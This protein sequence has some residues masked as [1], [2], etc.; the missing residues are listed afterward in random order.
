MGFGCICT[1]ISFFFLLTPRGIYALNS[2]F[3]KLAS[4]KHGLQRGDSHPALRLDANNFGITCVMNLKEGGVCNP[5]RLLY[6]PHQRPHPHGSRY[7]N[8][9]CPDLRASNPASCTYVSLFFL[10]H[11]SPLHDIKLS[12]VENEVGSRVVCPPR[13]D[14]DATAMRP[15]SAKSNEELTNRVSFVAPQT[16]QEQHT[17]VA[18]TGLLLMYTWNSKS[19]NPTPAVPP[20]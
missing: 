10:S 5:R 20:L 2:Q 14:R 13:C 15:Q 11:P 12:L 8:C 19:T 3:P 4:S 17:R 9:R 1:S 7:T 6:R 16:S 18:K